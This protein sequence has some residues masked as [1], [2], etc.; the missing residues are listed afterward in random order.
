MEETEEDDLA[1][2]QQREKNKD[3]KAKSDVE[4]ECFEDALENLHISTPKDACGIG[5]Q[6][7]ERTLLET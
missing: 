1:V 3:G 4:D 7:R 6:T 2:Q 5:V